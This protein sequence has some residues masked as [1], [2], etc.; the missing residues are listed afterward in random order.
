MSS[1]RPMP[2]TARRAMALLAVAAPLAACASDASEGDVAEQHA[3]VVYGRDDRRDVAQVPAWTPTF[4]ESVFAL[5]R[6]QRLAKVGDQHVAIASMT[7]AEKYSLCP[8]APFASQP[9]AASCAGVLIG[10]DLLLTAGHCFDD[11]PRCDQYAYVAGYA[12]TNGRVVLDSEDVY[13]CRDVLLRRFD[14]VEG[15]HHL[16][17]AVVR[18]DR[19]TRGR[20]A[21][22]ELR[23]PELGR[24][25]TML[26]FPNGLPGKVD[27]GGR[28]TENRAADHFQA[29]LDAFSANSGSPVFDDEGVL[30]GI[31]VAGAPRDYELRD[32]CWEPR[33][34]GAS[35]IATKGTERIALPGP[36]LAALDFVGAPVDRAVRCSGLDCT[37]NQ[38]DEAQLLPPPEPAWQGEISGPTLPARQAAGCSASA[39]PRHAARGALLAL[40]A[41][42]ALLLRHRTAADGTSSAASRPSSGGASTDG[43]VH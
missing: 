7:L 31:L 35:E 1:K 38:L 33:E 18:L 26:G 16:D 32:G 5:I 37:A 13:G 19:P 21:T 10:V 6:G 28:V 39:A 43:K 3:A 34:V 40:L 4:S 25:L 15:S 2:P 36:P 29:S 41:L 11:E 12:E 30:R 42:F 9:T 27:A 17:Y 23:P 8:D 14:V 20:P 24:S 22:V